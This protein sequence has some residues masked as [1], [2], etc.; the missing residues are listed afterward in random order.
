MHLVDASRHALAIF[1]LLNVEF[2]C[3]CLWFDDWLGLVGLILVCEIARV[4]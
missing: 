3:D 4:V 2:V 1:G